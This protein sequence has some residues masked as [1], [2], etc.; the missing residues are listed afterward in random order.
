VDPIR[1]RRNYVR[2]VRGPAG[3]SQRHDEV[4]HR[5]DVQGQGP[6]VVLLA[7]ATLDLRIWARAAASVADALLAQ[8]NVPSRKFATYP[9]RQPVRMVALDE[10]HGN[11]LH[12][13]DTIDVVG[14][15]DRA[16]DFRG[17]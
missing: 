7:G 1:H 15:N 17:R 4:G 9:V 13:I 16:E 8:H 12:S 10:I 2:L 14:V 11:F 3:A 6:V 5:L